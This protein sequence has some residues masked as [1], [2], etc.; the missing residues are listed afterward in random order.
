MEEK[1]SIK[2]LRYL[3]GA[4][5]ICICAF[6]IAAGFWGFGSLKSL[7]KHIVEVKGLS[8]KIVRADI[9]TLHISFENEREE[10]Y[11]IT[12]EQKKLLVD[13][14]YK[15][16]TEDRAYVMEFL[17]DHGITKE[18]IVEESNNIYENNEWVTK[19]TYKRYMKSTNSIKIRTRA[20][21]KILPI[22]MEIGDLIGKG[23]MISCNYAYKITDFIKIKLEMMR[24][25]SEN[26][27]KNAE[28]FVEPQKTEI[29]DLIYLRQGEVSINAEDDGSGGGYSSESESLNKK[30]RLVVR[31]GYSKK[32]KEN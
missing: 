28:V 10:H 7:D 13:E 17:K 12:K 26:A 25:A 22:K 5:V 31:A 18:E 29:D 24:E 16:R 14:L 3:F 21:E 4:F 15:K 11:E 19:D 9:G 8:E 23:V 20:V 2:F 1:N 6:A 27:R 32:K 30:L